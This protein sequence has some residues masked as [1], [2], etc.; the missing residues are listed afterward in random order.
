VLA[1]GVP[2][3]KLNLGLSFYG[4]SFN[5]SSPAAGGLGDSTNNKGRPGQYT[6]EPGFLAYY[7][8]CKLLTERNM[9]TTRLP[10]TKAPYAVDGSRWTGYDDAESI[11]EKAMYVYNQNLGG[12][13]IWS[14]DTDD[15]H[16]ICGG[17]HYPLMAALKHGFHDALVGR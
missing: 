9:R 5:L 10:G 4:R 13:A 15:F 11:K 12:V 1:A 2:A 7:E 6:Q 3:K 14:L 17:G 16:G 8:V